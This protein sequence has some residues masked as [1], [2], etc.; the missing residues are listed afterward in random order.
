MSEPK[1]SDSP[2][3]QA[4][5]PL[6]PRRPCL[7]EGDDGSGEAGDQEGLLLALQAR[8]CDNS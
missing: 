1:G 3:K 4:R 2:S 5:L 6:E 8:L 7:R